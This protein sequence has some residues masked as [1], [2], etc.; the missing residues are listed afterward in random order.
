MITG[1]LVVLAALSVLGG[2]LLLGDWIVEWLEPVT[3]HAEHHALAVSP[4]VMTLIV[5]AVVAA[6]VALAWVLVGSRDVP[7]VA[8][9]N[10]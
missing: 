7:R 3:G 5:T 8:P 6:G 9:A 1:P 10:V 2:A 4:L